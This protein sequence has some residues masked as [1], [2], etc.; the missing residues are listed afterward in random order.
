VALSTVASIDR[1]CYLLAPYLIY[2]YP[3]LTDKYYI[4]ESE[5]TSKEEKSKLK[6]DYYIEYTLNKTSRNKSSIFNKIE[7][8]KNRKNP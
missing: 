7:G 6:R 8:D 1:R 4:V 3:G 5:F 2:I